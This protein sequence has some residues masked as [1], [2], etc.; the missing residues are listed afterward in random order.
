[1]NCIKKRNALYSRKQ[2]Y[3]KKGQVDGLKE[4]IR[5]L[6]LDGARLRLENEK[7]RG[8]LAQAL[9]LMPGAKGR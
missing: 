3:K 4:E 8:L 5:L 9:S 1:M 6:K 2:Y 7:L